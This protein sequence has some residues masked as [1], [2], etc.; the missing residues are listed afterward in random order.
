MLSFN[1]LNVDIMKIKHILTV[2]LA[3]MIG[4]SACDKDFEEINTNPILPA[5]LDPVYQFSNAQQASAI[6]TYHYQG[7]IVQQIITPYG[8]VL[9][10]GNRNTVNEV[11]SNPAFNTLYTGPIRDLTDIILKLKDSPDRSNLYN[12]ARIWRAYCFQVLVD[13]Y[14]DVP[15]SEAGKGFLEST[16]LPKYDDQKTVYQDILKEYQEATD[17]L[18]AGKEVVK[19]DLFYKGDITLWKKLGNSL[20]LR[21]GMRYSKIDEQKARSV[22][23]TAVD[24]AR[25]GVMSS[26]NDN[27]YIQFNAIYTN[28]TSSALLGGEKANYYIGQPFVDFL[29]ATNDPRL[30]YIAV[31]YENPTNPLETAGAANINPADQQGMPYGYD[32]NS[33]ATAPGFPGKIGSAFKYSQFNRATVFRIDAPEFLV[34]CAQTQ[35]L[36]AEANQRGYI[37]TGNP[38]DFYEAGIRAH[39]TQ[40]PLFGTSVNITPEQQDSYLQQVEV[41]FDPARALEQINEQY[42]VASFRIWGEAWANFRRSGY[43]QLS[44]IN[45]SGEDPAVDAGTA[46]GF[47][48]RLPYPLREKSVNTANVAEAASRIGGDNLG[49]R[50]FWDK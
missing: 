4:L 13:T 11:N 12:M 34:T 35:L 14:G 28:S 18:T 16:Y 41:A 23:A 29:K 38:K 42:W 6:P 33:V 50:I 27:A 30:P 24:P 48:H 39:M 7:E 32:E 5:N 20:L 10:G 9:E 1:S 46:G 22:V 49:V 21:A 37:T 17:G 2:L 44:P 19:S 45:F 47:I 26:N 3:S 25:G 31:K 43:P 40:G 15:Y 8:G 36:L